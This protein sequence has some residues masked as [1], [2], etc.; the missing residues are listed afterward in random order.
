VNPQDHR[1]YAPI[2]CFAP[3]VICDREEPGKEELQV[4]R[5]FDQL[6]DSAAACEERPERKGDRTEAGGESLGGGSG[7]AS[8]QEQRQARDKGKAKVQDSWATGWLEKGEAFRRKKEEKEEAGRKQRSQEERLKKKEEQRLL[9]QLERFIPEEGERRRERAREIRED[10]EADSEVRAELVEISRFLAEWETQ[11]WDCE[12]LDIP[13]EKVWPAHIANH[14]EAALKVNSECRVELDQ[15]LPRA[16]HGCLVSCRICDQHKS[17]VDRCTEWEEACQ[18][19]G[20]GGAE[21][22]GGV[23]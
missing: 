15:H 12:E 16:V 14:P 5:L 20:S 10:A 8:N 9:E 19:A 22:Q 13:V 21:A 6:G 1:P 18:G 11:Q 23:Q 4:Q 7:E 17:V 2:R 3:C